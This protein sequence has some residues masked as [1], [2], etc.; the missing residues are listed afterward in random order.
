MKVR[1]CRH[2]ST[3]TKPTIGSKED[4]D[5]RPL[6]RPMEDSAT[7]HSLF[8]S[9]DVHC[10]CSYAWRSYMDRHLSRNDIGVRYGQASPLDTQ[11][12]G[13]AVIAFTLPASPAIACIPVALPVSA[14]EMWLGIPAWTSPREG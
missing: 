1:G 3:Y 12:V 2:N 10:A 9:H 14:P 11:A 5:G 7:R 6:R 4:N 8:R 13:D